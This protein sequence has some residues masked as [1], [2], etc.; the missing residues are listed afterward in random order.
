MET[1]PTERRRA[2]LV[3]KE[4]K[5]CHAAFQYSDQRIRICKCSCEALPI[6]SGAFSVRQISPREKT[7]RRDGRERDR[8]QTRSSEDVDEVL[9]D[10]CGTCRRGQPFAC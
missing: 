9:L 10:L 6:L 5:Q 2:L 7:P 8:E 1:I 4:T 3:Q